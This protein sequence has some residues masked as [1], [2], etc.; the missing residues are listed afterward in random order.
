V[1]GRG[2]RGAPTRRRNAGAPTV[3]ETQVGRKG[4]R[5]ESRAKTEE[6]QQKKKGRCCVCVCCCGSEDVR[7]GSK[8]LRARQAGERDGGMRNGES[9]TDGRRA[10]E[11]QGRKRERR[12]AGET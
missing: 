6:R 5:K 11:G 1:V 10:K 12:R 7:S 9:E 4:E 8:P 3:T 2:G